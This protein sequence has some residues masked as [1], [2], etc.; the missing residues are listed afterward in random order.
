[1]IASSAGPA[2]KQ[3]IVPVT[4]KASTRHVYNQ[5]CIR[6]PAAKRQA[7]W[8]GLKAAG[9]GCEVYYPVPLHLQPCFASLGC[10]RGDCPASEDAAETSLALPIFPESTTE[11]RQYVVDT[12]AKLLA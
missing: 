11:Q 12:A 1:M 2:P 7:V 3:V 6:L 8:D 4:E 10:K 5:Y 9:V